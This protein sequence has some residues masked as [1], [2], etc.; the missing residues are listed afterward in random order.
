[1]DRAISRSNALPDSE[2][3]IAFFPRA[4]SAKWAG[5]VLAE[6]NTKNI[7]VW[8]R[9]PSE[10]DRVTVV[11][12]EDDAATA[13]YAASTEAPGDNK[14]APDGVSTSV[15]GAT[16]RIR[17]PGLAGPRSDSDAADTTGARE[18]TTVPT[19]AM[20]ACNMPSGRNLGKHTGVHVSACRSVEDD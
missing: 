13:E 5:A 4:S 9:E 11:V 19:Q 6:I 17:G 15:V 16:D 8:C 14:P 12:G 7:P 2:A 20:Y 18:L 3:T 1:M 10:D